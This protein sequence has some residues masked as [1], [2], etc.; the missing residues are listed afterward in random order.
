MMTMT[1][2]QRKLKLLAGRASLLRLVLQS[3]VQVV[4]LGQRRVPVVVEMF[5]SLHLKLVCQETVKEQCCGVDL[6][7][8]PSLSGNGAVTAP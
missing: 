8:L 4:Q 5:I 1:F 2:V 7:D 3:V 6:H